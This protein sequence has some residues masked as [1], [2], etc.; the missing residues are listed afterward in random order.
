MPEAFRLS[1]CGDDAQEAAE[2]LHSVVRDVFGGNATVQDGVATKEGSGEQKGW[3]K[4]LALI[5][6]IP[7]A[8]V[9][10][11]D[12]ATRPVVVEQ[13]SHILKAA[14]SLKDKFPG[15]DIHVNVS[16]VYVVDIKQ[17]HPVDVTNQISKQ[18]QTGEGGK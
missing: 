11:V 13:V 10:T 14:Q 1:I 7:S 5:L 6:S 8:L 17:A 15:L 9:S 4:D 12:L 2:Q 16:G 18:Q 3:K